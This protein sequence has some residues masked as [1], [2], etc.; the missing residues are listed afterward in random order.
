VSLLSVAHGLETE[1]GERGINLSGGQKARVCLARAVYAD[2]DICVLD[3]PLSAVDAHVSKTLVE[4][5]T[6]GPL[7]KKTRVLVTHHLEVLPQADL[8]ITMLDGRVAEIGSYAELMAA[9]G[10]LAKLVQ[11][12]VS[13][14]RHE[15]KTEADELNP[16]EEIEIKHEKI[17]DER[18]VHEEGAAP[19]KETK[20]ASTA[21]EGAL[22]MAEE[23]AEGAV[24]STTERS[25]WRD[26]C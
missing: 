23:R 1:I 25:S 19:E 21:Q 2:S 26:L 22:M 8:I 11:E 12:H 24:V 9:E 13:E 20:K 15:A 17:E 3:D 7:A 4:C 16:D 6:T 5:F 18:T 14:S 10:A